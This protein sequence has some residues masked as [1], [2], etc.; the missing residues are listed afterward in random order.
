MGADFGDEWDTHIR[1]LLIFR[2]FTAL[3]WKLAEEVAGF[4]FGIVGGLL[5]FVVAFL[6]V[7]VVVVFFV[8]MDWWRLVGVSY[9]LKHLT[10]MAIVFKQLQ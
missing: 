3:E 5:F 4:K 9:P 6:L 8:L 1:F 7:V 10:V 2:K